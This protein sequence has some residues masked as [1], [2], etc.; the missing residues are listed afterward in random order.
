MVEDV[1]P[2]EYSEK[3]ALAAHADAREL[4]RLVQCPQ[5]SKPFNAP[6]TL[7]C[8]HTACRSCLPNPVA[9]T[10]ISYPNTPDRLLGISCPLASCGAEHA[11]AECSV[12]VTLT[13]LMELIKN[14]VAKHLPLVADMPIHL[15]EILKWDGDVAMEENEKTEAKGNSRVLQ[16][17]RL[18]STF[19]MA[20]MGDLRYSSEVEY[21]TLSDAHDDQDLNN[22]L[23]ERL[24]DAA[25]K[26]L[27]CHVCYNMML[28]PT[29]TSCGHTFCRRCLVRVM[30]HSSI[31]PVCRRGLHIPASLQNKPSN[32]LLNALLNGLCP[33]LVEARH[34]A[35]EA[36]EQGG[37]DDLNTPLFVC[38]LSLPTM[39]TFLH[40]FEPRY[41][42]MMRRCVEG[43]RQFGM[44]M[45][46]RNSAPQGDM[47]STQFLEYGTL[48]EIVNLEL[49]R[50]GRSFV[51]TRGIGRF[52]IRRHG[53]LDGYHVAR[54][55]R[56]EDLSLAEEGLLEQSETTVANEFAQRYQQDN[57]DM[58]L[59]LDVAINRF[60]TQEL[61]DNCMTFIRQMRDASA[62]WLS[63]RIVQVYGEPP[64]D[65]ALFPYWFAS[66]VPIAEEE[67][68]SLL[69]TTRV[70]ERL[71]IVYSWIRRIRGQ[72]W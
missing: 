33:E 49:L 26:E 46:N 12:D 23:L 2:Q 30:D 11:A 59:P 65:P 3:G 55:E 39:P 6:V 15:Q 70:R 25:Q 29:T 13:K 50:D 31:C 51:E 24:R 47:G 7:P 66:V 56:V 53:M 38:T 64:E 14:E 57:P 71:K 28:D 63:A 60:S 16:G 52:K 62:P 8:G 41:R 45:Y 67:K 72:R 54:V 40:V 1:A 4:V 10:N 18:V 34:R 42:L 43:N 48:L 32:T 5:C 9:R 35:V 68:Y 36:E 69:R 22:A 58:P 44:V 21:K 27:D 37:D 61:L 17:G 20:E 19:V